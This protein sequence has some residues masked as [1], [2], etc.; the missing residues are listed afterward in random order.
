MTYRSM[1]TSAS[2]QLKVPVSDNLTQW[3]NP[4]HFFIYIKNYNG[5]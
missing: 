4:I 3:I 1:G 2:T 5:N